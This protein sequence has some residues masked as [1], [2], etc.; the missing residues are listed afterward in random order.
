M[1][2]ILKAIAFFSVFSFVLV[3]F[4]P[5]PKTT[6]VVP[7]VFGNSTT[8]A[9]SHSNMAQDTLK[10]ATAAPLKQA[11]LSEINY[12][13]G[14]NLQEFQKCYP[15][16]NLEGAKTLKE[17]Y[18]KFSKTGNGIDTERA[19]KKIF[20]IKLP[21]GSEQR[22]RLLDDVS[23]DGNPYMRMQLFLVDAESLPIPVEMPTEDTTDPSQETIDK[24]LSRGQVFLTQESSE[25]HFINGNSAEVERENGEIRDVKLSATDG[26][27]A[28]GTNSDDTLGCKCLTA[29]N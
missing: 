2:R 7:E 27:F 12:M 25:V 9:S 11:Q 10:S 24:Y 18:A 1:S 13:S 8:S 16:I 3:M 21:D 22:L 20:H 29:T 23:D 19:I 4:W 28:C 26:F 14:E 17:L 6:P 5:K 15:S